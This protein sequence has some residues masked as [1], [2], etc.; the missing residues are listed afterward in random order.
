MVHHG[1]SLYVILSKVIFYESLEEVQATKIRSS[2]LRSHLPKILPGSLLKI[3]ILL[4][5][6]QRCWPKISRRK[7]SLVFQG[8]NSILSE[9]FLSLV[10]YNP[11]MILN[12]SFQW[13]QVH[14]TY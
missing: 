13:S 8:Q 14:Q 3:F 7:I 4:N 9:K 5:P 2:K 11:K 1:L 6:Y 10:G 12:P